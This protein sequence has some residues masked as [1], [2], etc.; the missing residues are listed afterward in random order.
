MTEFINKVYETLT[1]EQDEKKNSL[2]HESRNRINKESP[3]WGK[4]GNEKFRKLKKN[5]RGEPHQQS[6]GDRILGGEPHRQSTRDWRENRH[7]RQDRRNG[8]LSQRK[9]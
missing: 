7:W 6:T 3:N 4:T 8:Y 5:L 9:C 1:V 2:R